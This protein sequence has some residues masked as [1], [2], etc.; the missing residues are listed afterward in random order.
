MLCTTLLKNMQLIYSDNMSLLFQ[1]SANLNSDKCES[2]QMLQ[3]QNVTVYDEWCI[4]VLN[5]FSC[6]LCVRHRTQA[7]ALAN[8][9]SLFRCQSDSTSGLNVFCVISLLKTAP[10]LCPTNALHLVIPRSTQL[11]ERWNNIETT[12]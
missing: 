1:T 9:F 10:L 8:C 5:L 11:K 6:N 7:N 2:Q 3:F 4:S 12:G